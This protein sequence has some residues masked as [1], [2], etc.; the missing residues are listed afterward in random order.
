MPANLL[1]MSRVV[2]RDL[3]SAMSP[4]NNQSQQ[5]PE[6]SSVPVVPSA[7]ENKTN[8]ADILTPTG[9]AVVEAVVTQITQVQKSHS[10]PLPD[11]DTLRGYAD[12]I[13]QG[14]ERI[15]RMAEKEQEHSH[16][17]DFAESRRQDGAEKRA[18]LGVLSAFLLGTTGFGVAAYMA[19][20]GHQS[21]ER[22][23][24]RAL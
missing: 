20:L 5:A 21:K 8:P 6:Q 1:R 23:W 3:D 13:D 14:A 22:V 17:M 24:R 12:L 15:M 19:W 4:E 18:T 9:E 16:K 10:G 2:N 7:T 11:I